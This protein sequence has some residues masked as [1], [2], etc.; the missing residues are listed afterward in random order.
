MWYNDYNMKGELFMIKKED[1]Y[2]ILRCGY[3]IVDREYNNAIE[4][5]RVTVVNFDDIYYYIE[6]KNGEVSYAKEIG[7]AF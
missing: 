1:V 3:Y 2:E 5:I 6:R 4:N 7:G